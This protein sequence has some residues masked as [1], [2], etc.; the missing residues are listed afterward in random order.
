MTGR[1]DD[2][3]RAR[4]AGFPGWREGCILFSGVSGDSARIYTIDGMGQAAPVRSAAAY[5]GCADFREHTADS[6]TSER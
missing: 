3:L 2:Y 4:S 1:T 6:L 5:A